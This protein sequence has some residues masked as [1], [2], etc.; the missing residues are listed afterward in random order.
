MRVFFALPGLHR[1][2]RGA[3]VAFEQV[4]EHLARSGDEVTLLGTGPS[5]PDRSYRYL[6]TS[7]VRRERFE[8]L[9]SLPPFARSEYVLEELTYV[10]GLLRWYR[11]SDYDV[12]V[13]CSYPYTNWFLRARGG[14]RRPRHVFVTQNGDWPIRSNDAEFKWFGA[15]GVVCTNPDFE[16]ECRDLVPTALIPNGVDIDRFVPGD[17]ERE[18]LGLPLDRRIVV[19]VS[20]LIETKR[21]A[22]A[23]EAVGRTDDLMLVVAGDGPER[24]LVDSLAATH[25]PGRFRRVSLPPEDMP[26]LYRSA[27]AFLHMSL[28]EAFGNVYIEAAAC[29]TPIVA[30]DSDNTRWILGDAAALV[31]TT[32]LDLVAETLSD[33]TTG[34]GVRPDDL[35]GQ[36]KDRFSW[37]TVAGSYRSF[38]AEVASGSDR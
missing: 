8:K 14:R 33:A 24:D 21:V 36:V 38:L 12:T 16:R 29:G 20:A 10:P 3:E 15:D 1:V 22:A 30:H 37:A 32:D 7:T 35:I 25:L 27:D 4:A 11:P 17:A 19:M 13:T 5:R 6:S 23:V 34:R 9:P 18:R 2:S 26:S 28:D 31:D